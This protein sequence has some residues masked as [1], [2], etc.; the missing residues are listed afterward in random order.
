MRLQEGSIYVLRIGHR[1][2]RDVRITTHVALVA[3]A[4]GAAGFV[5]EGGEENLKSVR[6]VIGHWGGTDTFSI[7]AVSD[8]KRFVREWKKDGGKVVHLTMYG[9]NIG[10]ESLESMQHHGPV[11]VVVGAG[12][13]ERWYY[14]NSDWNIAIGNQPHSEVAALAIFL[15]RLSGGLEL[16]KGF[17]DAKISVIGSEHGK[18]VQKRLP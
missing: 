12:K 7:R 4:F 13:V 11:L 1:P 5:L 8:P 6:K 17:S 3:R 14:E 2:R 16:S 18:N 9:I 10:G 15:D